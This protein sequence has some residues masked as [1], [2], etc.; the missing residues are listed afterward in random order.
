MYT[1]DELLPLS[2]LQHLA[3]CPRQF[4]LIHIEQIWAENRYTAEGNL[5]HAKAD[6][7]EP[8]RR[9]NL[10]TARGLRL[11]SLTLGLSGIADVVEFHF[12]ETVGCVLSGHSGRWQPYPVEY[13]RGRP[14][15]KDCDKVQLCAQALCLEEMLGV[16][17]EEGSLFYG[18]TRR[19]KLVRFDDG[20]RQRTLTLSAVLHRLW[21]E[22]RTPPG[23]YAERCENCSL[24]SLCMPKLSGQGSVGAYLREVFGEPDEGEG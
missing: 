9:G 20:L 16:A 2:A 8:E 19:R 21:D 15:G 10:V 22:G 24:L 1:E 11:H 5:M 14:K 13:K 6:K 12:S 4:A 3:Y 7:G 18:K 23:E 17:I